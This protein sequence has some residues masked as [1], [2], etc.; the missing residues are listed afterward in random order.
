MKTNFNLLVIL[1]ILLFGITSCQKEITP[2]PTVNKKMADLIVSESFNWESTL[3]ATLEISTQM[4]ES[5]G[6]LVKISVY[7]ASPMENGNLIASG[8]AGYD[9]PYQTKIRIPSRLNQLFIKA[10]GSKG[11]SQ[12]V[13]VPVS[14]AISYTFTEPVGGYKSSG[15][16]V[17]DPDC[18]GDYTISG[19]TAVT[20]TGGK[21]YVVNSSY[22]GTITFQFWAGG[23]TLKVCGT[24]NL[25]QDVTLGNNCNII[26]TNGGTFTTTATVNMDG[27]S[28]LSAYSN[29]TVSIQTLNMNSTSSSLT[30]YA[31]SFT[32]KGGG[33]PNGLI[34]NHG[35]MYFTN[36]LITTSQNNTFTN[37]GTINVT[38]NFQVNKSFSN[39]GSVEASGWVQ[40]NN[41]TTIVNNCK[42]IGH[43]DCQ[44]N[45]ST[46]TSNGGLLKVDSKMYFNG[47]GT[48]TLSNQSMMA[49]NQL[50]MNRAVNGTGSQNSIVIA[51][52]IAINSGNKVSGAIEMSNNS[53]TLQNGNSSNFISGATFVSAANITNYIPVSAC[54]PVGIGTPTILDADGDG[55]ADNLD[56]YPSDPTRA[57]N[58]FFPNATS[59]GSIAFEDLWPSKGDY[60]FNDLVTK[61]QF[62]LVT[63]AQNNVVDVIGQLQVTAVGASFQNGF[64][65]QFDGVTP[66]QVASVTGCVIDE[67]YISLASNGVENN[68]AKAVVIPW[69][70]AENVINR[71]GGS[72]FNTIHNGFVGTS[73]LVT[74]NI[75]F[76][77]A[78]APAVVGT[79]PFNPFII[80]DQV[81]GH[82]IHMIDKIPTSLMNTALFGTEADVSNPAQGKYYRTENNLPWAIAIPEVFAYPLEKAEIT[83]AHLHF[84]AWAESEGTT[85]A[86]WYQDKPGYRNTNFIY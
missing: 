79:A 1:S 57:F 61:Y 19:N 67:G 33:S 21:T 55:V 13:S 47:S 6:S 44:I 5:I 78:L 39:Y 29:T 9:F 7:D 50:E 59:W 38:G 3:E 42:I 26:V 54:N 24:A 10:E 40:F 83:D 32:V 35:T 65:I 66:S 25:S 71:A 74:V 68:Q 17:V 84:A 53:G 11:T 2:D 46:Y 70:N 8:S 15:S 56:E 63:N 23:G 22:T 60:D 20:I 43:G 51:G 27:N 37:N 4:D 64:G 12:I 28:S 16:V 48:I 30:T 41:N 76:G 73:D 58:S 85:F 62:K 75:H 86:D 82:E 45:A 31:S 77:T 81:R 36:N 14:T 49:A 80:R 52:Q 69:D 18:T 34:V 72:M